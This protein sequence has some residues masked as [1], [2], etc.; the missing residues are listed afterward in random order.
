MVVFEVGV[1]ER[2]VVLG[3]REAALTRSGER[4]WRGL[5]G[6]SRAEG[7]MNFPRASMMGTTPVRA[8]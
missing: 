6:V 7:N 8:Y 2:V 3:G 5:L 1:V 4:F